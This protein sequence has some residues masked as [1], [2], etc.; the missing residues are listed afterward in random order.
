VRL[1][2]GNPPGGVKTCYN[3]KLARCELL[4]EREGHRP[5]R[6]LSP[7]GAAFELLTDF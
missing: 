5:R 7:Q 2:Y 6:L 4:L 3:T 1:P